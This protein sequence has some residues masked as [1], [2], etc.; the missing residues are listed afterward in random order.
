MEVSIERSKDHACTGF[1]LYCKDTERSIASFWSESDAE[2]AEYAINSH[3]ANQALITK[4]AELIKM[5]RYTLIGAREHQWCGLI[6][7]GRDANHPLWVAGN[8]ALETTKDYA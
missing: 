8:E 1:V 2:N 7:N 5:L 4:Q 3:D 6:H